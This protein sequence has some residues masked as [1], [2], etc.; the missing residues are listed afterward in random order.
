MPFLVRAMDKLI[1]LINEHMIAIN[2][3]KIVMPSLVDKQLWTKSGLQSIHFDLLLNFE[4]NP[5]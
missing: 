4:I 5:N 1:D 3:Q 2:A